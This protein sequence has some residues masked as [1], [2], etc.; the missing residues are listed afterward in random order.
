MREEL[1][2]DYRTREY[3]KFSGLDPQ[4]PKKK[5][6]ILT[7]LLVGLLV[8]LVCSL[9]Y[10]NI[11]KPYIEKKKQQTE[12]TMTTSAE[13][14]KETATETANMASTETD[15]Y[16]LEI[17]KE[18]VHESQPIS[19]EEIS[20][21]TSSAPV[22]PSVPATSQPEVKPTEKP[23]GSVASVPSSRQHRESE[24]STPS[25]SEDYSGLSTLEIMERKNHAEVVK[26]AKRAGV[27]TEGSTLEI[28][29]RINHA[30]LV[31]QAK[32]AG[33]STEGSTL[34]I[35]ERINHAEVVKQAKRAGVSTEGSTLEIMERINRKEMLRIGY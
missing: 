12:K 19:E 30:E 24:T 15:D 35:M 32:R 13:E 22:L 4:Q 21:H 10:D 23:A 6:S 3:E 16:V 5:P 20:I 8:L 29:E 26:Q 14:I 1:Y 33:V 18:K 25:K 11:V 17:G 2:K 28:M 34:E 27:C 9:G 31:K 7:A